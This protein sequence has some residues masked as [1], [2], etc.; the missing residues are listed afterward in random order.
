MNCDQFIDTLLGDEFPSDDLLSAHMADCKRC[1]SFY[2]VLAPLENT[3][4]VTA[5]SKLPTLPLNQSAIPAS[6]RVA[7]EAATRLRNS[8]GSRPGARKSSYSTLKYAAAFLAGVAASLG[9][10]A[11]LRSEPI[12]AVNHHQTVCL[13]ETEFDHQQNESE[14]VQSCVACHLATR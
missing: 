7:N 1:A 2:E 4:A 6:I 10:F 13:W 3:Q 5:T 12:Q 11:V 8:Q 14:F 9:G